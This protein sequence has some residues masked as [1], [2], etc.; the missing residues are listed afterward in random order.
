MAAD[1]LH[2]GCLMRKAV[3]YFC[4]LAV[5]PEFYPHVTKDA[6]FAATEYAP[7]IKWL[8]DEYDDIYD[9]DYT[10]MLR[11]SFMHQ[12]CRGKLADLVSLLAGRDFETKEFREDIIEDSY[13]H[14]NEGII[15]FIN[16]YNF[17]QFVLA[18]KGA[19]YASSKLISSNV[20]LDF[21]YTLYLLLL[22][23]ETI[24]NVQIKRYV[25]KWFVLSTLTGRYSNSPESMMDRDLRSIKEKGFLKFLAETEAS[26]LSD[27]FWDVTLPQNLETSSVNS[28]AFNT[29]IAAQINRNAD[30]LF[31][32][33][34]KY[35]DLVNIA[36]D[37]HH[38]F[39]KAYLKKNGVTSKTKYN[40]VANY[41]YLDTQVNKAISD[42]APNVYFGKVK[43][44]IQSGHVSFGNMLS[45]EQLQKNLQDNCIPPGIV[46]MTVENYEEFLIE[47]RKLM[48][49]FIRDY[50]RGL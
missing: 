42:D 46:D 14:L 12:F 49:A 16:E 40:Q 32:R 30:S 20:A 29:F 26:L 5:K 11:V 38:I 23:D 2:G 45:D 4:H 10:D 33:G 41:I 39:P 36:G 37:I 44:M 27:T 15:N 7:K 43:D 9:P 31:M 1:S 21:G 13:K 6:E 28:P 18:V 47:R 25:Q 17:K 24:P 35:V 8:K 22:N 34:T 50:Y 19:G 48:A 3:D